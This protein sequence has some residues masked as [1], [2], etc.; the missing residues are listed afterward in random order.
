VRGEHVPQV[1][2]MSHCVVAVS[3]L[4]VLVWADNGV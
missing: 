1:H 2:P 4:G 3:R